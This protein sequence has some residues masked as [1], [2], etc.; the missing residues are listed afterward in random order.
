MRT[1]HSEATQPAHG[2]R[3]RRVLDLERDVAGIETGRGEGG[4][5]HLCV[6]LPAT[7][8]PSNT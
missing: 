4:L 1:P 6:G 8:L 2:V 7:G 3:E 5:D